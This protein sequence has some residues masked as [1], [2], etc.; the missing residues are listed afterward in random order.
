[1]R[2]SALVAMTIILLAAPGMFLS[3][4]KTEPGQ[5]KHEEM[6]KKNFAES[7]KT[8]AAKVNGAEVSMFVL[9][10]EMNAIAPQYLTQGK[11]RTPE[12]D[13][14]I[15]KDALNNVI[16]QELA[17][18]E[19]RKRGM[20][21]KPEVIDDE[22]GKLKAGLGSSAAFEEYLTRNGLTEDEL[23][24]TIERDVL[25]EMI[26]A[27]EIDAKITIT[28][29]ALRKRYERERSGLRDSAHRQMTFEAA[30]GQLEQKMR[31]E[32]AEARMREWEKALK[33]DAKIGL[34]AGP[35]DQQ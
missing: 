28:E 12:L 4:K 14:R 6:L 20:Q 9:L 5:A 24:K 31:T 10:R 18:Q 16:V 21:A 2:K 25:F 30:R 34:V 3:C 15:R 32:A 29:A 27:Q 8:V 11:Q 22:I 33:K 7:K 1:M 13:E 26:A 17:V 19:A 23:R 35:R